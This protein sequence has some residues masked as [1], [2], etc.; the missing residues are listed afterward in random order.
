MK[1]AL[2]IVRS[3]MGLIFLSASAVVLF[4]LAPQPEL[5]GN[6]KLFMDGVQATGYLLTLIKITELVCSL[7]FLSGRFSTLAT[8]VLFPITLNILLYHIFTAPEGLPV[9]IFV[10]AGN[11]FLAYNYRER[12]KSLFIAK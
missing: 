11:L 3:L 6:V 7:S 4:K 12:Y 1:I 5:K 8:A 2:I 9:A 10:F